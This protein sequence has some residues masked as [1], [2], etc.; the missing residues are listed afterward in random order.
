M[1]RVYLRGDYEHAV[2]FYRIR[3]F[4]EM[5]NI[6]A[7]LQKEGPIGWMQQSYFDVL[8]CNRPHNLDDW[9]SI[10]YAKS[11]GCKVIVD[12]DDNPFEVPTDNPIWP[13]YNNENLVK[14]IIE[15]AVAAD[16]LTLATTEL[17]NVFIDAISRFKLP[18]PR[19]EVLPNAQRGFNFAS[20]K[21]H[22]EKSEKI[23]FWRGT[24]THARDLL[25]VRDA[26]LNTQQL[27]IEN[28]WKY[29][30]QGYYPWFICDKMDKSVWQ[31][32]N[33]LDPIDYNFGLHSA[34]FRVGIYPLMPHAFNM[35]KSNIFWQE[36]TVAGA[37]VIAPDIEE[38]R[39]P[40]A[41]NYNTIPE[42]EKMLSDIFTGKISTEELL[43]N[44]DAS[45]EDLKENFF[46]DKVNEKR[47]RILTEL[48][49]QNE[50]A[51]AEAFR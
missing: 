1:I 29:L 39:R 43:S 24:S 7:K 48:V 26:I 5:R 47:F 13:D 46:L 10:N 44:R 21:W 45:Y 42:F 34:K 9:R 11:C 51:I 38:F 15:C 27:A 22:K 8:F 28:G 35:S 20:R 31:H 3:P 32:V 6:E 4:M 25:T 41:L 16:V 2:G 49:G 36:C 33:F 23:I 12:W 40:G 14:A 19:V 50:A 30:F 37:T 18:C 17:A